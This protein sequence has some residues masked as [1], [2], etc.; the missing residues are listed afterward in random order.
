MMYFIPW[1]VF[2]VFVILSVPIA[3]W[4]EKRK[5]RAAFPDQFDDEQE[6]YDEDQEGDVDEP[7]AEAAEAGEGEVVFGDAGEFAPEGSE[8][9][10]AFEDFK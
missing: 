1:V 9:L 2:L 3:S 10:S 7:A 8:D 5:R 6:E 4:L